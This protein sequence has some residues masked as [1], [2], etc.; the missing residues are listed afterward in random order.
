MMLSQSYPSVATGPGE[1]RSDEAPVATRQPYAGN[2]EICKKQGW[3]GHPEHCRIEGESRYPHGDNEDQTT[4]PACS[5]VK[6]R[7]WP[8]SGTV[9]KHTLTP[10]DC[11]CGAEANTVRTKTNP[12]EPKRDPKSSPI[13]MYNWLMHVDNVNSA[14]LLPR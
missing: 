5:A 8:G 11:R 2:C 6:P 10:P 14:V 13:M 4:C 7:R 12:R 1:A 3:K 9:P